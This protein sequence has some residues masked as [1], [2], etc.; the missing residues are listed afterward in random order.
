MYE[1]GFDVDAVAKRLKTTFP[2]ELSLPLNVQLA[3]AHLTRAEEGE[4]PGR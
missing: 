4:A 3:L 2:V 1:T